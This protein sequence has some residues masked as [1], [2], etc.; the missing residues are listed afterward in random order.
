MA[1]GRG[2][3]LGIGF[4]TSMYASS[5]LSMDWF[6]FV[7][8]SLTETIEELLSESITTRYEEPDDYEGMHSI[9]GDIVFEVHPRLVGK[10]AKA[11]AGQE[12]VSYQASCYVHTMVP[13]TSDWEA[14]VAALQPL[15][16]EIYR[17]TGSAYLYYD[18]MIN[19]LNFELAQGAFY[20]V[21]AGIIGAEFAWAAKSTP[22]YP[23]GSFFTWNTASLSL[24][25]A[26]ITNANALSLNF[27]NGLAGRAFID[28]TKYNRRIL[29]ENWRTCEISGTM[30]LEGDLQN[31]AYKART[32]QRLVVTATDP[33]TIMLAHN[34]FE[35]DIPKMVYTAFPANLAGPG[36]VE[37]SF[38]GKA[39]YDST[40]AYGMQF[41]AVNTQAAYG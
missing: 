5:V 7:S 3:H 27:N 9:A 2:G 12:S 24:A 35:I 19:A 39:K 14:G 16:I 37:V 17:D 26:A 36:L 29:R 34:Q 10:L 22:S 20:K 11:W 13:K 8:E 30:L 33:T 6:P 15:T 1:Y 18:C 40:S 23:A 41:I 4:Q 25:G 31:R 38:T 32:K 21:T 28:G